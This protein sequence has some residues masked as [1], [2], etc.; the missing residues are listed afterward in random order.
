MLFLPIEYDASSGI[1]IYGFY[2][3]LILG[4]MVP[5]TLFFLRITVAMQGL[6]FKYLLQLCEMCHWNLDRNYIETIDCFWK[7]GHFNDVNS[8]HQ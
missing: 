4:S 3:G 5:P 7:C 1:V 6:I 2:Y 8:S